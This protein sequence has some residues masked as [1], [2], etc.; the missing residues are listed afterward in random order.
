MP[1]YLSSRKNDVIKH[2]A[3][4]LSSSSFRREEGLFVAEGARLCVDALVSGVQIERFFFSGSAADK[5]TDAVE[6]LEAAAAHSYI[7]EDS[8][9]PALSDT[10]SPQGI[11]CV[12]K[13]LDKNTDLVK[14]DKYGRTLALEDIQD[15]ANMG[16]ILRTA[17]ALG[18][19][20]VI[21]S[22]GCCDLFS[23]KTLRASMGAVFRLPVQ[24]VENLAQQAEQLNSLGMRTYASVPDRSALPVTEV[25][26]SE[27][28]VVLIGNEGNGLKPET[29]AACSHRVTIPMKG[30]AESLNAAVAAS[31]LMWEM[32]R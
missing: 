11:F 4:L 23:P 1:D 17:E 28:A 8:V 3:K 24:I 22:Q 2:T 16:A 31:V 9:L 20:G 27:G 15:P 19:G 21:L 5:Y 30:R 13:M 7:V 6:K 25:D 10:K 18:I 12:C 29:A 26:F 14:M 32:M